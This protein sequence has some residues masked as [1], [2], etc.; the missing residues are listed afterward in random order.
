MRGNPCS[1]ESMR[2]RGTAA[3]QGCRAARKIVLTAAGS[4]LPLGTQ[5]SAVCPLDLVH[6]ADSAVPLA[7]I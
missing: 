1:G 6:G 3:G 4:N 2:H 5:A 7:R